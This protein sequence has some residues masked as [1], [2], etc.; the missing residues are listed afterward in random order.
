MRAEHA[1]E[2]SA[3]DADAPATAPAVQLPSAHRAA[4]PAMRTQSKAQHIATQ[5][6]HT[7]HNSNTTPRIA[8]GPTFTHVLQFRY[9]RCDVPFPS[10]LRQSAL[11]APSVVQTTAPSHQSYTQSPAPGPPASARDPHPHSSSALRA[12]R[13]HHPSAHVPA[14][15]VPQH[16]RILMAAALWQRLLFDGSGHSLMAATL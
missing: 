11:Q 6:H 8:R 5:H 15:S 10:G 13:R 16:A 1:S 12:R 9:T 7:R 4:P 3:S 14:P 2:T